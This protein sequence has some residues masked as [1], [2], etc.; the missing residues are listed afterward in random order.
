[1]SLIRVLEIPRHSGQAILGAPEPQTWLELDWFHDDQ[2]EGI[3]R[4]VWQATIV[5]FLSKKRYFQN[6][7]PLLVLGERWSFTIGY[8][9]E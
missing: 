2:T 1:M 4:E 9:I 8:G 7:G 5:A 6:A 3:S